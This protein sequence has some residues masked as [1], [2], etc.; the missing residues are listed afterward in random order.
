MRVRIVKD[1][2]EPDIF[3]QTP[4][5]SGVWDGISFTDKAVLF[6][7]YL[8][9]LNVPDRNICSWSRSGG[10]W[11]MSQEPPHE[12]YRWQTKSYG[13]FDRIYT[14]WDP[15]EF[16]EHRIINE[17]TA[18]PW[19]VNRSY[20]E[21]KAMQPS[22][23]PGK[24][25]GISW[26]TSNLNKRPGHALR[27][28]FMEFLHSRNF[29]FQL[30]GRGFQPIADKFDGIAPYK[31]SIAIENFAC[32]DYWTEKI[33]DCL[34]SWTMPI[35]YGALNIA[36]YFPE[37]AMIRID[38]GRP[39]EALRII[40]EAVESDAWSKNLDYIREARQLILDKYQLFPFLANKIRQS[41]AEGKKKFYFIPKQTN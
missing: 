13:R 16:R 25:D 40:R 17:Q 34:L 31:Y 29:P 22:D 39:E 1:W 12:A 5:G 6:C 26:I 19:H 7:D 36:S 33:A 32:N 8:V 4:S 24:A 20:D 21:L 38:P 18:L 2:D 37:K 35:Y 27:L 28:G 10:R 3:R 11:L 9:V 30:F 15:A 14:F 23:I 41:G